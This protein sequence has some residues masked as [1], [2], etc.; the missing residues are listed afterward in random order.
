MSADACNTKKPEN[1]SE[2][3]D[4]RDTFSVYRGMKYL[5]PSFVICTLIL[6]R[7]LPAAGWV[8]FFNIAYLLIFF[9]VSACGTLFS[10]EVLYRDMCIIFTGL[11][12]T[13]MTLV[14]VRGLDADL[15]YPLQY[16]GTVEGTVVCDSSF[17]S[18]GN[19][20]MKISLTGCVTKTGDRGSASGILT[21][22]GNE[23][24]IISAGVRV[25]LEGEFRDDLF[26]YREIQVLDRSTVNDLREKLMVVL[27]DRVLGEERDNASLTSCVLLLGRTENSGLEIQ[28][29]AVKCG[30]SH[31]FALS[32]MHLGI[33]A[34]LCMRLFGKKRFARV[35]SCLAV[36]AFVFVAGPRASLLRAALW[37]YLFFIPVRERTAAVFCLHMLF[38]PA[39]MCEPGCC[40]GYLAIF[41]IVFFSPCVRAVL[42]QYIGRVSSLLSASLS[43]LML[44][45]PVYIVRNGSWCPASIIA[46]PAAGLLAAAS[47]SAGLLIMI[48]GRLAFLLKVNGFIYACMD[49]LFYILSGLPSLRWAGYAVMTG[50]VIL[51]FLINRLLRRRWQL[52][53][54]GTSTAPRFS[55]MP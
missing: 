5:I 12:A 7:V 22:V 53:S 15:S 9:P 31:V 6:S 27:E 54:N 35:M 55:R 43:V 41:A 40:Y 46:S 44:S 1:L 2:N 13:L 39:S 30:C 23:E 10:S 21:V 49:C 34:G 11:A 25:R 3:R 33:F 37:F 36:A 19:H 20:L 48:F 50:T 51:L 17:T 24:R 52:Q 45:A 28:K 16:I 14:T 8:V 26:I 38:F 47:M 32:G 4:I 42:Y 18:G 29:K